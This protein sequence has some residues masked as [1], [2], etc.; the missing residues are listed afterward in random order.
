MNDAV[1]FPNLGN[2]LQ[3]MKATTGLDFK[4]AAEKLVETVAPELP[5][6]SEGLVPD[7]S[8]IPHWAR[9]RRAYKPQTRILDDSSTEGYDH[10][11]D[12]SDNW[13]SGQ[14]EEGG[15]GRRTAQYRQEMGQD[16]SPSDSDSDVQDTPYPTPL[17]T[18]I[19][20]GRFTKVT[21][22]KGM[23]WMVNG[24]AFDIRYIINKHDA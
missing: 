4:A 3:H 15:F 24:H 11:E 1:A 2:G 5:P 22:P 13:S 12:E 18:P 10:Y 14:Q 9:R 21:A 8:Y 6:Y 16:A 17:V 19:Y 23:C 7:P 20:G